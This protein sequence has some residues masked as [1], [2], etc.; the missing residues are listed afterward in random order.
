M[1]TKKL[2]DENPYIDVRVEEEKSLGRKVNI[3]KPYR[4]HNSQNS[5]KLNSSIAAQNTQLTRSNNK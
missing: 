5:A 3:R 1:D 2:R 4:R